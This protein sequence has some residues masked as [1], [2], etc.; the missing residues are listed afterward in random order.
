MRECS[1]EIMARGTS[2]DPTAQAPRIAQP[3]VRPELGTCLS[4]RSQ[5]GYSTLS[6]GRQCRR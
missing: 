3:G 6:P 5:G 1:A 2:Q 4:E